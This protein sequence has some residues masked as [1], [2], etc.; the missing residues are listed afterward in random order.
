MDVIVG[1]TPMS[2]MAFAEFTTGSRLS[3]L[4]E[5]FRALDGNKT[6]LV[7]ALALSALIL[8]FQVCFG[9]RELR[10]DPSLSR[11]DGNS[12][13]LFPPDGPAVLHDSAEER[14]RALEQL[15]ERRASRIA[16]RER[17]GSVEGPSVVKPAS[18]AAE[19]EIELSD[20]DLLTEETS[21]STPSIAFSDLFEKRDYHQE[22]I[23]RL[24]VLPAADCNTV[25]LA[26]LRQLYDLF[27][28]ASSEDLSVA[29]RQ[30]AMMEFCNALVN[31]SLHV[32]LALLNGSCGRE[33]LQ[34][35]RPAESEEMDGLRLLHQ[36]S[37][38]PE[39]KI[40]AIAKDLFQKIVPLCWSK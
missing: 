4:R 10:K 14:L 28:E 27:R 13:Q 31:T 9:R 24:R 36:L 7:T 33:G 1:E 15:A 11:A 20:E 8:L 38:H 34:E 21:C 40:A 3:F 23:D 5:A 35:E 18:A 26:G 39:P 19:D 25:L 32:P 22:C 29:R 30:S 2:P 6:L 17:S 12:K 16:L 37:A